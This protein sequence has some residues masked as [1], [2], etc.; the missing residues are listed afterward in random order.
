M[1]L[2]SFYPL[3]KEGTPLPPPSIAVAS[4]QQHWTRLDSL[5]GLSRSGIEHLRSL[6]RP[7]RPSAAA[8]P[9][10]VWWL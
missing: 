6:P 7:E 5:S 9:F 10:T 8:S 3:E 4:L 1:P 2:L